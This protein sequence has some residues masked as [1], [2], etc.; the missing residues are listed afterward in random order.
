M[1]VI[2]SCE[3]LRFQPAKPPVLPSLAGPL[4][5]CTQDDEAWRRL[6][7]GPCLDALQHLAPNSA[8]V[9]RFHHS[10][11]DDLNSVQELHSDYIVIT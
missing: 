11:E 2:G 7:S 10:E 4:T 5:L 6:Q 9:E 3:G 1:A 8:A